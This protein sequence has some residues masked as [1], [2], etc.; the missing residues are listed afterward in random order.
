MSKTGCQLIRV[1]MEW[2]LNNGSVYVGLVKI[3]FHRDAQKNKEQQKKK[4]LK[5]SASGSVL[6]HVNVRTLL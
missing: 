6:E 1:L 4:L 5:I 3:I 2:T